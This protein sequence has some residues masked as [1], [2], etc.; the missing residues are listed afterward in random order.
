M[1]SSMKPLSKSGQKIKSLIHHPTES[2]DCNSPPPRSAPLYFLLQPELTTDYFVS[3]RIINQIINRII[4]E[5]R[6]YV[7]S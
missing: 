1:K 4:S 5:I 6:A 7:F 3:L 2:S